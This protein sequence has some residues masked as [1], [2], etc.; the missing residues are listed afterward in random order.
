[1]AD[2]N[3]YKSFFDNYGPERVNKRDIDIEQKR[4]RAAAKKKAL[5]RKRRFLFCAVSVLLIITVSAVTGTVALVKH[6]KT[7]NNTS[8]G[9][10][11]VHEVTSSNNSQSSSDISMPMPKTTKST[12]TLGS[13][14]DSAYAILVDCSDDTVLAEKLPD[15]MIYPASMTKVMT[16]L[17]A[18]EN[19]DSIDGRFTMTREI[20][21]PLYKEGASRAGFCAGENVRVADMFYG[22][23]LESGAEAAVGLAVY[24]SGSEEK[25]VELMNK[26]A[27]ELGLTSTHFTNVTG[28]HSKEHYTTCR[29]MAVIMRA[30]LE[31][32]FCKAV[33]STEYYTVAEND[34]H[35]ELKFHSTMLS[36]MYGNEPG[37]ATI[38]G[39]KTGFTANSGN[40]LVSYAETD[41]G[42]E[43]ICVTADGGGRYKPIYDCIELYKNYTHPL[44]S[45]TASVASVSSK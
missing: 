40:C 5:R 13:Q 9:T 43:I 22:T 8:S 29:E 44:S 28:L 3:K 18:A 39:G 25:F 36:R 15:E 1:M 34:F 37:V 14:I 23:I 17:V 12:V 7:K 38:K 41:D 31:N 2:Y 20:I 10:Y 33:L 45:G 24:V 19:V 4:R 21:D 30:A 16:L 27:E 35:E 26:K 32:D 6:S 42:R 11:T